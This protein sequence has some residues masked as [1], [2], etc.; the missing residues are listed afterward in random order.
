MGQIGTRLRTLFAEGTG[1]VS[2][3]GC[4]PEIWHIF[5]LRY[6]GRCRK[7]LSRQSMEA[8]LGTQ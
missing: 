6:H 3:H 1:L 2:L 4:G 8:L 5:E 7:S